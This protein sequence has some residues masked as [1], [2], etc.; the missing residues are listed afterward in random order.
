[1]RIIFELVR[2]ASSQLECSCEI[3]ADPE[4]GADGVLIS[5]QRSQIN[6]VVNGMVSNSMLWQ[7]LCPREAVLEW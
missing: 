6:N 7:I 4:H 5:P 2:N 1:M 3:H